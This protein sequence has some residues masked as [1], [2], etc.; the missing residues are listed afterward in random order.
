MK[1][2]LLTIAICL[3]LVLSSFFHV[4]APLQLGGTGLQAQFVGQ[5]LAAPAYLDD[6]AG[7]SA[8]TQVE[9]GDEFLG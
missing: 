8:W 6:V 2:R 1:T 5:A 4:S 3:M 9:P 7:I